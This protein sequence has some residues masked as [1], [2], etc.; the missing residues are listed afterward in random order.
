MKITSIKQQIK[1][2]DRASIFLD[3]KY[4]FSLTLNELVGEKLKIGQ[5]LDEAEHK[6]LKKLSDDGK[7]RAR[8]MEWVMSRPRS[9][10]EFRDY[11]R[12]KKVDLE[13]VESL[14][15]DFVNKKWL[16]DGSFT[17]WYVDVLRR[18]GKSERAIV[19]ELYK[20][21]ISRESMSENYAKDEES[22]TLRLRELIAK[23]QKISR[24]RDD[25][26]KLKQLLLRQGFSY[27]SIKQELGERASWSE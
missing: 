3:S 21:G 12:R 2:P 16:D 7:I 20:K 15:K 6:R 10:R 27:D 5:E 1:N 18:R 4:A 14:E 26:D 11:L 8:A 24:Y 17:N 23:K 13:L 22:E 19:A 9:K 25:K